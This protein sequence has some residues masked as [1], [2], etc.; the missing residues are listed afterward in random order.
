MGVDEPARLGEF[1]RVRITQKLAERVDGIDLSHAAE[2]DVIEL[3]PRDGAML[4]AEHWAEP[5]PAG[6]PV[7]QIK[8]H[9]ERAVAADRQRR[10]QGK[11][12]RSGHPDWQEHR[13]PI[14]P[15]SVPKS[16]V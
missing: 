11:D 3:S 7:A 4:I 14:A 1:M 8:R 13:F 16:E 2:G 10:K 9:A 12:D 6:T 5:V 15:P